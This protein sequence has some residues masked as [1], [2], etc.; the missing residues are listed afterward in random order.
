MALLSA[1]PFTPFGPE[2][3][4]R[5]VPTWVYQALLGNDVVYWALTKV[6]RSA[7]MNAF[8]AREELRTGISDPEMAFVTDLIDGFLPARKRISGLKNE[9]AAVDPEVTYDLENITAPTLVVHARDDRLN[10]FAIGESIAARLPT[11]TFN[12]LDTGGHLLLGH[13][14]TLKEDITVLFSDPH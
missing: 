13:H 10:P 3:A 4:A 5:P 1:A 6:A 8:D 9:I 11:A 14:Q 2:V 12:S 7:L